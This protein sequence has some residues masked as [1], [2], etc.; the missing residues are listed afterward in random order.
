MQD[1]NAVRWASA[2]PAWLPLWHI[3]AIPAATCPT[4]I[5]FHLT[6]FLLFFLP[7]LSAVF[8]S[9]VF[10]PV[11][12]LRYADGAPM[13]PGIAYLNA[14][15]LHHILIGRV[16]AQREGKINAARRRETPRFARIRDHDFAIKRRPGIKKVRRFVHAGVSRASRV[17]N[18]EFSVLSCDIDGKC[19][20]HW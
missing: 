1:G 15:L 19:F 9:V 16:W 10:A 18:K 5:R 12:D 2:L 13:Q 8:Y 17:L 14:P 7:L 20:P 11:E 3:E 6:F 4:Y